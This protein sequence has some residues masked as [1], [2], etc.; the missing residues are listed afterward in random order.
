MV[1][2]VACYPLAQNNNITVST[3]AALFAAWRIL[4]VTAAAL[5]ISVY[6]PLLPKLRA[7]SMASDVRMVVLSLFNYVELAISYA[8]LYARFS[9]R[10]QLSDG[11]KPGFIDPFYFSA[12]T[13]L[14]IGY[15]DI[16]PSG[17]L[18]LVACAQGCCALLI[19]ALLLGRFLSLLNSDRNSPE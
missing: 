8:V 6:E 11:S 3:V 19:L 5:R 15:G 13:Q 2:S 7:F 12:V 1:T 17:P 14:T 9:D 10:L 4:D 16:S 18:K